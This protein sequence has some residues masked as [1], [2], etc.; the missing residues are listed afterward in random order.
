MPV[1]S[2][3]DVLQLWAD[4]KADLARPENAPAERLAMGSQPAEHAGQLDLLDLL[5][6]SE[7]MS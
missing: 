2:F 6:R 3:D 7:A 5:D 4:I 1:V